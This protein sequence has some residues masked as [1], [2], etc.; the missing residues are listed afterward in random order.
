MTHYL[1]VLIKCCYEQHFFNKD[2][3]TAGS[4]IQDQANGKYQS[5]F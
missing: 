2:Y 1:R 4:L 5:T 3:Y